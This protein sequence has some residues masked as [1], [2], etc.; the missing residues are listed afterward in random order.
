MIGEKVELKWRILRATY[1]AVLNIVVW[2][3]IPSFLGSAV[4]SLNPNLPLSIPS[5]IYAFGFAITA[6][7]VLAALTQGQALSAVFTTGGYLTEAFYIWVATDGGNLP[8][9]AN[10]MGF[11][12]GF[13]TLVFLLMLPPLFGAVRAP[14]N[15]LLEQSEVARAYVDEF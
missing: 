13:Q 15:F 3:V 5:Y 6:V 11:L 14:L 12:I 7:Q 1:T 8:I 9:T 4:R 10:G 2:V